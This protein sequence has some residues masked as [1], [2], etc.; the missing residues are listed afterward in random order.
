MACKLASSFYKI[1]IYGRGFNQNLPAS[2]LFQPI[3]LKITRM[4]H[5]YIWPSYHAFCV[6]LPRASKLHIL[7]IIVAFKSTWIDADCTLIGDG[8]KDARQTTDW[9]IHF[10]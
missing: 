3:F 8:W 1:S 5:D 4:G 2:E 10:C 7:L 6:G 9:F